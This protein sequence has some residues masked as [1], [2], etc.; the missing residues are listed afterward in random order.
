MNPAPALSTGSA[1]RHNHP[2]QDKNRLPG[3]LAIHPGK[4]WSHIRDAKYEKALFW[5]TGCEGKLANCELVPHSC[6]QV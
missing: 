3:R 6:Y 1:S 2:T 4:R 5:N